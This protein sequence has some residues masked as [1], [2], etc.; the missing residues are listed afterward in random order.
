MKKMGNV[1]ILAFFI[2]FVIA[3]GV[4]YSFQTN[5]S[6]YKQTL[7]VSSGGEITN[8]SNYKSYTATGIIAGITNSSTYKNLLGFFYTWLLADGQPCTANNQCEG[9]Y[10]CS[11]VCSSSTCPGGDDDGDDGGGGGGGAAGG[12]GGGGGGALVASEKSYTV[13]PN[14]VKTKISLG[15]SSKN[16]IT[17]KNTGNGKLS[18]SLIVEGVEQYLSLSEYSFDLGVGETK[19]ITL[20]FIGREIGSF[21]G[22][23][24]TNVG[25]I[26]EVI[27]VILEVISKLILFDAKL[28][29]P[30]AYAVVGPG[31]ELKSQI[32]LLNVGAPGNVDVFVTY[33]IKDLRGN[34]IYEETETFAVEKQTSFTKSFKIPEYLEEGSYVVIMEVKYANSF[35]VSSQLFKV[36]KKG[37]LI[38]LE[39]IG[40]NTKTMLVLVFVLT[41]FLLLLVYNK[42]MH[43]KK[44][45]HGKRKKRK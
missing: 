12:G 7:I 14:L 36:S 10:C 17:I 26:R 45:K 1:K 38:E 16:T 13:S 31:E 3:A 24:I 5:S 30:T 27:P 22:Q 42:V 4:S 40:R 33:F 41:G 43:K 44:R 23:I 34:I 2:V 39:N 11:N 28:D 20:S 32:T 35:A 21:T 6:N 8:S 18:V 25:G 19:E 15:E 9:G 29:I 37:S